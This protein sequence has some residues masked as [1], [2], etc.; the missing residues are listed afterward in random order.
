[1]LAFACPACEHLVRF[2]SSL[3]LNCATE[4][5]FDPSIRSM[6]AV[7]SGAPGSSEGLHSKP[8]G[9]P[10][11]IDSVLEARIPL[12][13]ALNAVGRS[14]GAPDPIP[15]HPSAPRSEA[16]LAFID[17]LVRAAH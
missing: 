3:C 17:E 4:L 5:G 16:K 14:M 15:V 13:Y 2:E 10:E 9:A 12:T 1:M 7:G 8:N 11:D 6:R